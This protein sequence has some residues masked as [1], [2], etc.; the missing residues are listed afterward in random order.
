MWC[1][2]G[3]SFDGQASQPHFHLQLH[4]CASKEITLGQWSS[5]ESPFKSIQICIFVL[6]LV[7]NWPLKI[8]YPSTKS[9]WETQFIPPAWHT[10]GCG[11]TARKCLQ[12]RMLSALFWQCE[13][14]SL[15]FTEIVYQAS[16][17]TLVRIQR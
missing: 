3:C 4:K 16:L 5:T 17:S 6:L 7:S 13:T 2:V 8:P 11:S 1:G 15:W 9:F 14:I 10:W 12:P